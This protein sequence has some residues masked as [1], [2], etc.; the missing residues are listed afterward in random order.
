V[1]VLWVRDTYEEVLKKKIKKSKKF[2]FK[3][4]DA[5]ILEIS[6]ILGKERKT[7]GR[8]KN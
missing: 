1:T 3:I 7:G 6:Y 2:K 5:K 8:I 4:Y